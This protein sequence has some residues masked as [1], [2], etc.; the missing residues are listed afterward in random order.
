MED[1]DI[2]KM[3]VAIIILVLLTLSFFIIKPIIFAVFF[4][5]LLSY[6]FS[7]L[8]LKLKSKVKSSN[9]SAF[10]VVVGLILIIILLSIFL[11]PIAVRQT[12]SAYES[13]KDADIVSVL[14]RNFPNL[15]T[16]PKATA[17][18]I[19]IV[20]S[21]TSNISVF[22]LS[23]IKGLFFNLPLILFQIII[24]LFTFFFALRDQDLLSSYLTSVSPFPREYQAKF[25]QKF[26]EV[27]NSVI[28]GQIVVGLVQGA[29]SGIGYFVLG[30]P[31]AL[32]FTILT[33]L[34]GVIPVIGP[35]L[36][37]IPVD[38]SLFLTGDP[39]TGILLLVYGL[40]VI[41]LVDPLL[42]PQI[43]GRGIK[44]NSAV[45]LIGM[46]GGLYAFGALGLIIGPLILA[47]LFLVIE[48]YKEGRFK[49]FIFEEQKSEEYKGLYLVHN[50]RK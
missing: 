7:P 43:V 1:K 46:I 10:I 48:F 42:G 8:Y 15:F 34:A 38:I 26:K 14:Q 4:G 39:L 32:L 37:W 50:I 19:A 11:L 2:K 29:V 45:V 30:V 25:A 35:W 47:Y 17:D 27:V 5:F 36:V 3:F 21:F 44:M 6:I 22:M 18:L 9:I 20:S 40:F 24:T 23:W 28:F 12:L 13:I 16:S 33:T 49:S 31:H 41:N